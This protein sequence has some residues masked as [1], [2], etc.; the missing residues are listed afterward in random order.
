MKEII[1]HTKKS[2]LS[3][4]YLWVY[5]CERERRRGETFLDGRRRED[6]LTP[7]IAGGPIDENG[8]VKGKGGV[9]YSGQPGFGQG[10]KRGGN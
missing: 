9:I 1:L 6:S 2:Q 7:S 4:A 10:E 5:V 3:L 8:V